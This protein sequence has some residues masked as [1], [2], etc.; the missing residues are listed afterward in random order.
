MV[1][2]KS[3]VVLQESQIPGRARKGETSAPPSIEDGG[4]SAKLASSAG[5]GLHDQP[6]TTQVP[7]TPPPPPPGNLATFPLL[8]PA[9]SMPTFKPAP[10][11]QGFHLSAEACNAYSTKSTSQGAKVAGNHCGLP[12]VN[13]PPGPTAGQRTSSIFRGAKPADKDS[14]APLHDFSAKANGQPP[15]SIFRYV[16]P[17]VKVGLPAVEVP[18]GFVSQLLQRQG[19]GPQHSATPAGQSLVAL[20][21]TLTAPTP[22]QVFSPHLPSASA[23]QQH[24]YLSTLGAGPPATSHPAGGPG[25][26]DSK[27]KAG[28]PLS[29]QAHSPFPGGPVFAE[30]ATPP[31]GFRPPGPR[32]QVDSPNLQSGQELAALQAVPGFAGPSPPGPRVQG[33]IPYDQRGQEGRLLHASSHLT[34]PSPPGSRP[35]EVLPPTC[36]LSK[37]AHAPEGSSEDGPEEKQFRW[38]LEGLE[39]MFGLGREVIAAA[40]LEA[41][42]N[43]EEAVALLSKS[44]VCPLIPLGRTSRHNV[45]LQA[46]PWAVGVVLHST[47]NLWNRAWLGCQ[48]PF[49]W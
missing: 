5:P 33:A 40:Y 4:Q 26:V 16:K 34:H 31:L 6:P 35:Q 32:L 25:L 8:S 46:R 18:A 49:G 45:N 14:M 1:A 36:P 17:E 24:V 9:P 44:E 37:V 19:P 23:S 12:V 22:M 41:G 15:T 38:D 20:N 28:V 30:A 2:D 48:T 29:T 7:S 47:L 42:R 3:L 27:G 11:V 21:A 10:H 39:K 43:V 13:F